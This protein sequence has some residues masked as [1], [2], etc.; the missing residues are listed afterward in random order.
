MIG[1]PGEGRLI[2]FERHLRLQAPRQNLDFLAAYMPKRN[3]PG[4]ILAGSA[5]R[6]WHGVARPKQSCP[7]QLNA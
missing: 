3:Y 1:A 4:V 2:E 5:T 7:T 6:A